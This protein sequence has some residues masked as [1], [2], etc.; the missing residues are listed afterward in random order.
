MDAQFPYGPAQPA[1]SDETPACPTASAGEPAFACAV[2]FGRRKSDPFGHLVLTA[3]A[4]HFHGGQDL[5]VPWRQVAGVAH[6][7]ASVVI[8]L[9]HTRRT[10]HFC[11]R[12][13]AEAARGATIAQQLLVARQPHHLAAFA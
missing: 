9:H 11:C 7:H 3:A 12:D 13:A 10:L 2:R 5:E 1:T 4:V 6:I 8:S